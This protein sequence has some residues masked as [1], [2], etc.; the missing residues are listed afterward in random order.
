MEGRAELKAESKTRGECRR[1]VMRDEEGWAGRVTPLSQKHLRNLEES[2][3][4][5]T[6]NSK[7]DTGG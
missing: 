7:V 2:E 1:E 4:E 5:Q 6:G 3:M